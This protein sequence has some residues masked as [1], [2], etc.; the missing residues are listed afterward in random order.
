MPIT[1]KITSEIVA[2]FQ[3]LQKVHEPIM[4]GSQD[5][6]TNIAPIPLEIASSKK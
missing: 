2:K 1:H 4:P 3:K 5:A 6:I